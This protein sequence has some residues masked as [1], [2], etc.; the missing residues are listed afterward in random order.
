MAQ[1]S[2][3]DIFDGDKVKALN[4]FMN[5]MAARLL[6]NLATDY[7]REAV[8]EHEKHGVHKQK[9]K[10]LYN[11]ATKWFDLY[12][13]HMMKMLPT[14]NLSIAFLKDF[15]ELRAIINGFIL[16]HNDIE[17]DNKGVDNQAE[18]K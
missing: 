18:V 11:N 12:D 10:E 5:L 2:I 13:K 4:T 8:E 7:M 16:G 3:I 15:D 14:Q 17:E 9:G 1:K 6:I